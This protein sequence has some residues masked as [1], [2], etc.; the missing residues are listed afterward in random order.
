LNLDAIGTE[1]HPGK[2]L[3]ASVPAEAYFTAGRA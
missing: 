3:D 1:Q 2:P